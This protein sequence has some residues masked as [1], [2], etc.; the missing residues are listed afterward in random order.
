MLD[1]EQI[2]NNF[3]CKVVS[4]LHHKSCEL[5]KIPTELV[6]THLD[7]FTDGTQKL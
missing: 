2:N 5:D 4:K 7:Y 1:F 6:K 3:V